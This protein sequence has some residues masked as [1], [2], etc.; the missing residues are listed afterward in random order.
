M[1]KDIS[2]LGFEEDPIAAI[3]IVT[4]WSSVEDIS[5]SK[6]EA[7][8][9]LDCMVTTGSMTATLLLIGI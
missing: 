6:D 5:V 3:P 7:W 8:I 2:D 4:T 9:K 1:T